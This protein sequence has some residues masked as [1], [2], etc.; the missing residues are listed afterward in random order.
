MPA[1]N[2]RLHPRISHVLQGAVALRQRSIHRRPRPSIHR[3]AHQG[4]PPPS[5]PPPI[6]KPLLNKAVQLTPKAP[7]QI[8]KRPAFH[9][10][11][12]KPQNPPAILH[13]AKG[14]WAIP[15]PPHLRRE[16]DV[17]HL[18]QRPAVVPQVNHLHLP[19]KPRRHGVLRQVAPVIQLLQ[20]SHV[21]PNPKHHHPTPHIAHPHGRTPTRLHS[22]R[23]EAPHTLPPQPNTLRLPSR[24]NPK[25]HK[26][27]PQPHTPHKERLPTPKRL[28]G[29]NPRRAAPLHHQRVPHHLY[30]RLRVGHVLLRRAGGTSFKHR[31]VRPVQAQAAP[32][33]LPH[34]PPHPQRLVH[35]EDPL[36][37]P[38][39][40]LL[41]TT[42][43]LQLTPLPIPGPPRR[44]PHAP[45]LH[46][47]VVGGAPP[48]HEK[49]LP[50]PQPLKPL[51]RRPR[52]RRQ[53]KKAVY[54]K[55]NVPT[56]APHVHEARR[57]PQKPKPSTEEG[58]RP[59]HPRREVLPKLDS[60]PA[61]PKRQPARVR[62]PPPPQPPKQSVAEP[63]IKLKAP[64][65]QGRGDP[66]L[67][68]QA[69]YLRQVPP[70]HLS[71]GVYTTPKPLPHTPQLNEDG[72]PPPV[73]PNPRPKPPT[74]HVQD[75]RQEASPTERRREDAK[76]RRY[77]SPAHTSPPSTTDPPTALPPSPSA[78][79]PTA[80][81]QPP[82]TQRRRHPT[83]SNT[84]PNAPNRLGPNTGPNTP[85]T[86]ANASA[87]THTSPPR[88]GINS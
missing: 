15:P 48:K 82:S 6:K 51:R 56:P 55:D 45:H 2:L 80:S 25:P 54:P 66:H 16:L 36:S 29:D 41:L 14:I 58:P 8:F 22:R 47:E 84:P 60:P 87:E 70:R 44:P 74:P 86:F 27:I 42:P 72:P 88:P 23:Q 31:E 7:V 39:Q 46:H 52:R 28:E 40:N 19:R 67:P 1:E 65:P 32:R 61:N 57:H 33:R 17:D 5:K 73:K 76:P 75:L 43:K 21:P 4:N 37:N 49:P 59:P 38:P 63:T 34:H 53:A 71:A 50:T 26:H 9:L 83:T 35:A 10:R 64:A 18:R 79:A 11:H 3:K 12:L 68:Q 77:T 24:Q 81:P 78:T 20:K 13:K 69:M 85:S 62:R 30:P